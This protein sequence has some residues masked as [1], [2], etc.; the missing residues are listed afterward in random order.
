MVAPEYRLP[1]DI[2]EEEVNNI[3]EIGGKEIVLNTKVNSV[4]ELKA[5][6]GY[7]AVFVAA[8]THKGVKLPMEGNDLEDVLVNVDFLKG[9]LSP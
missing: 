4:D 8:G 2:I 9:S 7:D 3:R 1:R 6:K 5:K